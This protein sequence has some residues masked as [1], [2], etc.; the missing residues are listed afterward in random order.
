MRR[1]VVNVIYPIPEKA[2]YEDWYIYMMI[3]LKDFSIKFYEKSLGL[4]RQVPNSAFGGVNNNSR[5]VFLYRINRDIKM[6]ELFREILPEQYEEE[7]SNRLTELRLTTEGTLKEIIL[8][9]TKPKEKAK[10]FIKRFFY[11]SYVW[12]ANTFRK[13]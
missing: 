12:I 3:T 8:F 1:D 13:S 7:V 9:K 2:T 6:L 10:I 5:S 11:D 4:Y